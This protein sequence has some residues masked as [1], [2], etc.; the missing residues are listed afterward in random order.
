MNPLTPRSSDGTPLSAPANWVLG[1][2][3]FLREDDGSA[4]LNIDGTP[5]GAVTVLWNGTG[6]GDTGGDW[7]RSGDGTETAGSMRTGTNGHD[8]GVR[9]NNDRSIF[10]NGVPIDV[11]SLYNS[12]SFW[13]NPQQKDINT[14]LSVRFFKAAG[15]IGA[16]LDVANY[17]T[18]FDIGVWQKVTI[19]IAD[20]NL[21]DTV[22]EFRLIY[23]AQGPRQQHYYFDDIEFTATGGG[24]PYIFQIVTP[25]ATE[26]YHISMVSLLL[27]GASAGWNSN[28][29][30]NVVALTSGLLLR[31]RKLSTGAV[32][33]SINSKDNVDLFGRFHPQDD[34]TF[35]D[36]TLLVGFMVKPGKASIIVTDDDVLE[37]VVRD[38]L[39]GI[40]EARGF[41]HY[42]IEA[43]A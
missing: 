21:L 5:S 15:A 12:I 1:Q 28:T 39:S 43:I 6:A 13:M 26:R 30:A 35:A 38:D 37:L 40:T 23:G 41:A 42:A 14:T 19:P 25:D 2:M 32:A 10:N 18:N 16:M 9:G 29:F 4:P 20:F 33:W 24:G 31:Q 36:G 8:S 11:A 27:S 7:A 17:V 34:I 3:R 22:D